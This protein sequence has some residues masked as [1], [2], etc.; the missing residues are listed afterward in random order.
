MV[1]QQRIS[2]E[3]SVVTDWRMV[4]IGAGVAGFAVAGI[5][6]ALVVIALLRP[7][8]V[9]PVVAK[10]EARRPVIAVAQPENPPELVAP[11]PRRVEEMPPEIPVP[12][13]EVFPLAERRVVR[14]A[15]AEAV[16]E[17]AP[18]VEAETA[19]SPKPAPHLP[20]VPEI[21]LADW[22]RTRTA[23]VDLRTD[24]DAA[25]TL[26]R[27]ASTA[28]KT[29]SSSKGNDKA[30]AALVAELEQCQRDMLAKRL[31]L[32]GLPFRMGGDCQSSREAEENLACYSTR[33]RKWSRSLDSRI[34][35][36]ALSPSG[37]HADLRLREERDLK[38]A[39]AVPA[40]EQML[41]THSASVR[42][43]MTGLL[44]DTEGPQATAALARRALFDLSIDVREEATAALAKRPRA[45]VRKA[46]L[47]GTR[48]PWPPAT[49]HAVAALVRLQDQASVRELISLLD[50]PDPGDPF[51]RGDGKWEVAEM[52]RI[53]HLRNCQLCHPSSFQKEDLIRGLI[54]TPG[55]RLPEMYYASRSGEFV[56]A[57]IVYLRQDFSVTLPVE[58]AKPWPRMQR[59]DFVA[60]R[61]ALTAEEAKDLSS[62]RNSDRAIRH[63]AIVWALC[64]LTGL[65]GGTTAAEW[66]VAMEN[67][68]EAE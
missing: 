22:L 45:E 56:R 12:R 38:T 55:E 43:G 32:A 9:A 29:T 47:A 40:L 21:E 11:T 66:R 39:K 25:A 36:M 58:D 34:R 59:F 18:T 49:T 14:A 68:L 10:A 65:D 20:Y 46:L 15:T 4:G 16:K 62:Q 30:A 19:A 3:D 8:V 41:Q 13:I 17:P 51:E 37:S 2:E 54:P 1:G 61:R 67:Q 44:A 26:H 24:K 7:V 35:S 23:E 50:A 27:A 28:F 48:H 63:A 31:D 53:N 33:I 57:D 60:R 5:G 6:V 42:V 52:V 64:A